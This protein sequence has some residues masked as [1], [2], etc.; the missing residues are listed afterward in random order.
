MP[1]FIQDLRDVLAPTPGSRHGPLGPMLL[2]MTVVTGLV[3][4]FSYLSLGHVFVANMTGNVVL[5]GFA[6]AGAP[7][8]SATSSVLAIA[9]FGVGGVIG[10]RIG[11]RRGEHRGRHLA[12]AAAAQLNFV[13][14]A[15]ALAALSGS[16]VRSAYHYW[17]ILVL[18]TAMGIQNATARKLAVPDLTTTVLTLTI[19]GVFADAP[20][21]GGGGTRLGRRLV[22]VFAM[23]AGAVLG[24][25]F[26]VHALVVY[27][28]VIALAIT[29]GVAAAAWVLG[30]SG[31]DWVRRPD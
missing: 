19:T 10:G 14:L 18:A 2:G 17:L 1:S 24:A 16:P 20:I 21:G 6:L 3:D 30:R 29:V 13:A 28:L 5:L 12:A 4:A 22:P 31:P 7:G 11:A 25:T 27:P 15:V 23:L 8:F 9:A 26:V